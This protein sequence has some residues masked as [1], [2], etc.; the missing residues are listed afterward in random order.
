MWRATV[1]SRLIVQETE[2][3]DRP[4]TAASFIIL[5]HFLPPYFRSESVL[6]SAQKITLFS[7]S[8]FGVFLYTQLWVVCARWYCKWVLKFFRN[9]AVCVA[10]TQT[11]I[12][13]SYTFTNVHTNIYKTQTD[14]ITYTHTHTSTFKH[15]HKT[16][17]H[18]HKNTHACSC[19]RPCACLN[20]TSWSCK[21]ACNYSCIY[22]QRRCEIE[23]NVQLHT[24]ATSLS[25]KEH[26]NPE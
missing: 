24:A 6:C 3:A 17:T 23:I 12:T 2:R 4:L 15:A 1:A 19:I 26:R 5:F 22:S 10:H 9:M 21:E 13:R 8:Q 16:E 7:T 18:K 25:G 11:H 14:T 20:S